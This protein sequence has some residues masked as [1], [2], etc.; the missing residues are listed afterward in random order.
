[1][2]RSVLK[3]SN[4]TLVVTLEILMGLALIAAIALGILVWRLSAGPISIGFAKDYVEEALSSESEDLHVTFEDMVFTWPELQGPFQLDLSG[5][6]VIRGEDNAATLRVDHASV[7]LSRRA[8]LF[9]AIRP[10]SVIIREPTV[11]LVRT[12][13]GTINL[14]FSKQEEGLADTDN[15]EEESARGGTDISKIFKDMANHERGSLFGRLR[16]FEILDAKVAVRDQEYGLSWS[17]SDMDF[18]VQQHPQGVSS[19]LVAT[20]PAGEQNTASIALDLVY[21]KDSDD[22]RGAGQIKD[23][24]PYILARFLPVPDALA[25]QDLFFN[26]EM[27]ITLDGDLKPTAVKFAAAVPEGKIS[28]PSEYDTPIAIKDIKIESAYSAAE[29]M[30][31]INSLSGEIGG[32]AFTGEARAVLTHDAA[33]M[34]IR[35]HVASAQLSQ[36]PPLFPKSE[37]DG[38]AYKWLGGRIEGGTFKDVSAMIE[39]T[40]ERVMD[41]ETQTSSVNVDVPQLKL[42]FSFDDAKV[43]Y[44]DTLMPVEKASGK[45][46]LDLAAEVLEITGGK[47]V[48]GDI[49]GSDIRVRIVDLMRAGAGYLTVNTKVKGPV[50][51]ALSYIADEPIGMDREDI[52]IDPKTAKG[53]IEADIEVALPT[54]KDIPKEDV[55]VSIKGTLSDLHIP[56]IVE[57]LSLSGGPLALETQPGGFTI[58]GNA[59]LAGRDTVIDWHQYF[60]SQGNPYSM[61]VVAKVG[62]DKELR[63]HFGVNLDEYISGTMPVDV[64]YISKGKGNATVDVT[65]DLNPVRVHID[66]F[67]FEKP[68]GMPGTVSTN[69]V[70]EGDVL[71]KLSNVEVKSKTFSVSGAT[72]NFAPRGDKKADLSSGTLPNVVMGKTKMAVTFK[73]DQND[74]MNVDAKGAVFDLAP[75]L[76]ETEASERYAPVSLVSAPKSKQQKMHI[77]MTA[78]TMLGANGQTASGTKTYLEMDDE[79]DFTRIEYDAKVGEGALFVRFMPDAGGRRTFRLES[80]DAGATLNTLGLYENIIGGTLLIYGEP[81][82][83]LRGDLAGSMRMENF[84]V[85]RAPALASLLSLMSLTGVRQLLGNEGLVFSKLESGFEWRFR[86]EG[87]L[88]VIK[89]GTTSGSSVGLTFAGVVDR[90]QKT[91]DVAGT[92]I[93]MTEI[94]AFLS[95]IP[96]VGELLGGATGLIAATY[97]M[98]G[99]TSE[100]Q[101]SVNPLSV[102]APGIIRKILFE[103]GYQNKIPGDNEGASKTPSTVTPPATPERTVGQSAQ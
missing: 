12:Q 58:K 16:E 26:S 57:G 73:V 23:I 89:D 86:P 98:K 20:L 10:V 51:T 77:S 36:V 53:T 40:A 1:M 54:I 15:P 78:D 31:S 37:H 41:E 68:V 25:E 2:L 21:R 46:S 18:S 52:G 8:L 7:G 55:N 90:G 97:T 29:N 79:G 32:I 81:K 9:G 61:K 74:V 49:E 101:V 100:P 80:T 44:N 28:I 99:P 24:N 14:S 82:D 95:K 71:K 56:A 103:G 64:T 17:L 38:E 47:G 63:N 33:T 93:P 45:G 34:P 11:E 22:F 35:L 92:I 65:G 6:R 94:N 67:K 5:L 19:S 42:D 69:A 72:I 27:E 75:M 50:A 83:G 62:A 88:L 39:I 4:K 91:T 60:V 84:R 85:V 43:T 13:D 3:I 76:R 96:L 102:L 87:N 48:L 59:Q 30:L 66:P 70:L